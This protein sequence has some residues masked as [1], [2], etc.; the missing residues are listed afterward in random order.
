MPWDTLRELQVWH[1]RLATLPKEAWAPPIDV[2]E[3][4]DRYVITAEVPGLKRDHIDISLEGFRLTIRGR[5]PDP[6]AASQPIRFHQVERG[7]GPFSRT[8]ELPEEVDAAGVSADLTNG[9]LTVTLP[10]LPHAPV[11]TIEVG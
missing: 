4:A 5:R 9:I 3:T 7:R 10:K 6:P 11:R 1:E 2:Y 8:F